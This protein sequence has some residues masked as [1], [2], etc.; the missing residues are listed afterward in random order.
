MKQKEI[1]DLRN[2]ARTKTTSLESQYINYKVQ[3]TFKKKK[4]LKTILP[5]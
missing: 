4:L 3:V 5:T 1:V 2:K